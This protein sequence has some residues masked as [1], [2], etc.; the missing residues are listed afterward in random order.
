MAIVATV[1]ALRPMTPGDAAKAAILACEGRDGKA[2][3]SL[4]PQVERTLYVGLTSDRLQQIL[5]QTEFGRGLIPSGN[6]TEQD[7]AYDGS[8]LVSRTY[9]LGGL[10]EGFSMQAEMR[11]NHI[12]IVKSP[13]TSL[14]D[15]ILYVSGSKDIPAAEGKRSRVPFVLQGLR[16]ESEKLRSLG[17]SGIMDD[18][19]TRII[20]WPELRAQLEEKVMKTSHPPQD[21]TGH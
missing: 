18:E 8:A 4:T 21:D 19:G 14:L 13:V 9:K 17:F 6:M 1:R 5:D 20:P 12:S 11:E 15:F 10:S 2:L 7:D 3:W 16:K